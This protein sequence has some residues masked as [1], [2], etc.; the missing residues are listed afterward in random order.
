MMQIIENLYCKIDH[1]IEH[2]K[3]KLH[4]KLGIKYKAIYEIMEYDT[5]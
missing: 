2:E 5:Q 4:L 1:L 3:L